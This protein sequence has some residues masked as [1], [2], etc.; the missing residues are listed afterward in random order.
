MRLRGVQKQSLGANLFHWAC[1][2]TVFPPEETTS[3]SAQLIKLLSN[4]QRYYA[5]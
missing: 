5:L 3:T 4:Q 1:E 2:A